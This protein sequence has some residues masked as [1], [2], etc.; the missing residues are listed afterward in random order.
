VV[1]DVRGT[2]SSAERGREIAIGFGGAPDGGGRKTLDERAV[3][4]RCRVRAYYP[5]NSPTKQWSKQSRKGGT[6]PCAAAGVPETATAP[7]ATAK[8]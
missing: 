1:F 3:T 2:R 4:D 7:A 6:Q 5:R 8:Q